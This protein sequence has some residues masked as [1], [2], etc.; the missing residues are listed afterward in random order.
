[1]SP[2][3]ENAQFI[4]PAGL[5]EVIARSAGARS[6][7]TTGLVVPFPHVPMVWDVGHYIDPVT[8][9]QVALRPGSTGTVP[10]LP[11]WA[12]I[13]D[14]GLGTRTNPIFVADAAPAG[15][16]TLAIDD[17][18]GGS[19]NFT[20]NID[21]NATVG[22]KISFD[23]PY[24]G[25]VLPSQGF[26]RISPGESNQLRTQV[27]QGGSSDRYIAIGIRCK[28]DGGPDMPVGAFLAYRQYNDDEGLGAGLA[29]LLG[30]GAIGAPFVSF[31]QSASGGADTW[32]PVR[33]GLDWPV[34]VSDGTEITIGVGIFNGSG[35]TWVLTGNSFGFDVRIPVGTTQGPPSQQA[36]RVKRSHKRKR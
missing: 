6:T 15:G 24:D 13:G 26:I 18:P 35:A 3:Q 2:V 32:L 12:N 4:L 1:M 28:V 9:D 14:G 7:P 10:A 33:R 29:T 25:F 27:S 22:G 11:L 16:G 17:A 8:A 36:K 5:R 30:H 19:F 34:R 31:D 20:A 21:N 23:M